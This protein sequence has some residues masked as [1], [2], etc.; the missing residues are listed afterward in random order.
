MLGQLLSG[1]IGGPSEPHRWAPGGPLGDKF[2]LYPSAS[3]HHTPSSLWVLENKGQT[4]ALPPGT[5]VSLD[6]SWVTFFIR[7]MEMII[8]LA[9][10][11]Q[12]CW[13]TEQNYVF[14]R[15]GVGLAQ[16]GH[17]GVSTGRRP[18][19]RPLTS[20]TPAPTASLSPGDGVPAKLEVGQLCQITAV[21]PPEE[22]LSTHGFQS[23]NSSPPWNFAASDRSPCFQDS[24]R[25]RAPL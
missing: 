14:G 25:H 16:Q 5:Q 8:A 2:L 10:H 13:D 21:V 4:A 12:S 24:T 20:A 1:H 15:P 6:E 3:S 7:N 17:W 9:G 23:G 19:G 22:P 18:A 11:L